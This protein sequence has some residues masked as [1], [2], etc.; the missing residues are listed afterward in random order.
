MIKSLRRLFLAQY[1]YLSF[2]EF[3][4][5]EASFR[6]FVVLKFL[7]LGRLVE[8]DI[9]YKFMTKFYF[10]QV[11]ISI[12]FYFLLYVLNCFDTLDFLKVR[13]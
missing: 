3:G 6:P 10:F 12:V 2:L 13:L 1:E 11:L 7:H 4:I 9:Y 5:K 8:Y